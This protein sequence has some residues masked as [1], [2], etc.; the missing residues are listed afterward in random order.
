MPK[1]KTWSCKS[2]VLKS[3][4]LQFKK[5]GWLRNVMWN[6]CPN[7]LPKIIKIDPLG[8][9]GQ[10]FRYSV[11]FWKG[12]CFS[13][14]FGSA[15]NRPQISIFSV[16]GRE[17]TV[18]M[19]CLERSAGEAVCRGG[20]RGGVT[21]PEFEDFAGE[22]SVKDSPRRSEGGG[23]SVGYRLF[24]RPQS[25]FLYVIVLV[26]MGLCDCGI[27]GLWFFLVCSVVG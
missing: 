15:I 19:I 8:A 3:W 11:R 22:H 17:K 12:V 13:W 20:E 21:L 26:S 2:I 16:S 23:G 18:W 6:G 10:V 5:F 14:F 1:W 7:R 25:L 9:H 4:L 24:R 27:V